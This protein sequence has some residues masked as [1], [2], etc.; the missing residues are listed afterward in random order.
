MID[1]PLGDLVFLGSPLKL[2]GFIPLDGGMKLVCG[3]LKDGTLLRQ[4]PV[5]RYAH[6]FVLSGAPCL[7]AQIKLR[8]VHITGAQVR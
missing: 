8:A 1:T 4:Y 5:F 2:D 3:V 7:F 6:G